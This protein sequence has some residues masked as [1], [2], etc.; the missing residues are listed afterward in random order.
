MFKYKYVPFSIG[1]QTYGE[2]AKVLPWDILSVG[3]SLRLQKQR[4][5]IAVVQMTTL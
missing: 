1:K 5:C 3:E 4:C 2:C